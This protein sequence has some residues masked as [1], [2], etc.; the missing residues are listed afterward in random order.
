MCD[1]EEAEGCVE[2]RITMSFCTGCVTSTS[3]TRELKD[4]NDVSKL[5]EAETPIFDPALGQESANNQA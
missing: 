1:G 3:P 4:R 2:C 5:E